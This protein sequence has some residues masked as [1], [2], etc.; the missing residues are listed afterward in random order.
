MLVNLTPD[1]QEIERRK[2]V[3]VEHNF[4]YVP[5]S[6][7]KWLQ[8]TGIY[9]DSRAFNFPKE[10]FIEDLDGYNYNEKLYEANKKEGESQLQYFYGSKKNQWIHQYGVADNIEQI[11]KY[12][13][14]QIKDTKNK[15]VISVT[16][17]WQNKENK[18]KGGGWRWH[19]WGEYIGTLD[20]KCEHLDDED[21]G[22]D[23]QYILCFHLYH[24]VN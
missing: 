9:Q 14:K 23:F 3:A 12:Y 10:E 21:F 11:K 20:H 17:V 24:V 18:C 16:P 19:K 4:E 22:E 15:F 8:E 13:S 2:L 1:I 5:Q 7:P 6:D